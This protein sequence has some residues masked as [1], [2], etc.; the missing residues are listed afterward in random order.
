MKPTGPLTPYRFPLSLGFA[1]LVAGGPLLDAAQH[2]GAGLDMA[3]LRAL[4]A[5]VV[6]WI[7]TGIVD[8]MLLR[9]DADPDPDPELAE[10]SAFNP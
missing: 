8:K 3:L 1:A 10:P 5:A 4:G 7:P 9:V 6:M 2:D